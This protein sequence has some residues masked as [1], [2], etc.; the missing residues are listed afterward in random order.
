MRNQE[1]R[2]DL[3]AMMM[4]LSESRRSNAPTGCLWDLIAVVASVEEVTVTQDLHRHCL[5]QSDPSRCRER[6][7]VQRFLGEGNCNAQHTN[8]PRD[9][10]SSVGK[11]LLQ[12]VVDVEMDTCRPWSTCRSEPTQR[13]QWRALS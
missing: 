12:L 10:E 6:C 4:S 1:S 8:I 7:G 9:F 13:N 3:M 11:E 5:R 2:G